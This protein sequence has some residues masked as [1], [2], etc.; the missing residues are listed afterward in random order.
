MKFDYILC[1]GLVTAALL[2]VEELG[3]ASVFVSFS[4]TGRGF[5]HIWV[6]ISVHFASGCPSN[7]GANNNKATS[8]VRK[9]GVMD[10]QRCPGIA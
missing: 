3:S 7:N 5:F 2:I 9:V 8:A 10:Q 4:T 1:N 6:C